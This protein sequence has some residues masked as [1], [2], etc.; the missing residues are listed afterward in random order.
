MPA[1]DNKVSF[2]ALRKIIN[3]E[4]MSREEIELVWLWVQKERLQGRQSISLETRLLLRLLN[5][6]IAAKAEELLKDD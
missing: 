6:L 5:T 3:K 1:N 4:S 2:E